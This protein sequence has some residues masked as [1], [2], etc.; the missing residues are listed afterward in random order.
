MTVRIITA[1]YDEYEESRRLRDEFAELR[2]ASVSLN[3]FDR[4]S[5]Q[6]ILAQIGLNTAKSRKD[7]EACVL[8]PSIVAVKRSGKRHVRLGFDPQ[9]THVSQDHWDGT[10][11]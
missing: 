11:R 5:I 4:Q 1:E 8:Q 9:P 7:A 2:P 6:R 3:I 10:I